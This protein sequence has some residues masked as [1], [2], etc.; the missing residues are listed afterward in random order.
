MFDIR[1]AFSS[2]LKECCIV[3]RIA[4]YKIDVENVLY[5]TRLEGLIREDDLTSVWD[6][7]QHAKKTGRFPCTIMLERGENDR[8][9]HVRNAEHLAL[10]A[11]KIAVRVATGLLSR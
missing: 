4:K 11:E 7:E 8:F 9:D 5:R 10:R 3:W 2:R 1:N 6:C